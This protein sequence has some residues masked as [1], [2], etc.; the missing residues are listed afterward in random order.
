[1]LLGLVT[2]P[3]LPAPPA[4]A[5]VITAP[6]GIGTGAGAVGSLLVL[7]GAAAPGAWSDFLVSFVATSPIGD[8]G[9][10]GVTGQ[11]PF[12]GA[13]AGVST[14]DSAGDCPAGARASTFD[15]HG[16][17]VVQLGPHCRVPVGDRLYVEF[18]AQAPTTA[19]SL[20]V[21]TSANPTPAVSG[22]IPVT[23]GP[24]TVVAS[25]DQAGAPSAYLMSDIPVPAEAAG[26]ST[27]TLAATAQRGTGTVAWSAG[28]AGYM[29]TYVPPGG[30]GGLDPVVASSPTSRPGE[31]VLHLS[32]PLS[33]GGVVCLAAQ[34]S[35][36]PAGTGDTF[37]VKVGDAAPRAAA[38]GVD[39]LSAVGSPS[40]LVAPDVSGAVAL[41]TVQFA[42]SQAL[43]GGDIVLSQPE[44]DFSTVS[45][46]TLTDRTTGINY[47]V[48]GA[49]LTY[50]K[51]V[52]P[53]PTGLGPGDVVRVTLSGVGNP[54]A[55]TVTDFAVSTSADSLPVFAPAYD[56]GQAGDVVTVSAEP[57]TPGATADYELSGLV[58][59]AN[60]PADV[61]TIRLSAPVGT[62]LPSN[63]ADYYVRDATTAGS[64]GT[65][66]L[67]T[68]GGGSASVTFAVPQAVA[69]GDVMDLVVHDVVNP[70][71]SGV[72]TLALGGPV[73]GPA[74]GTSTSFPAA[75]ISYPDGSIIDFGGTL[76][77]MAGGH[78]FGVVTPAQATGVEAVDRAGVLQALPGAS[79]PSAPPAPG[80]L[81]TPFNSPTVYVVGADRLLHGF[82]TPAQLLSDGYDPAQVITVPNL[83]GLSVGAT[84][85]SLGMAADAL[86]TVSNGAIVTSGGAFYV[87]A[88]GRAFAVPNQ[89]V[90]A[91]VRAAD[92]ALPL[93]GYV[94]GLLTS[95]PV[96]DGTLA[97]VGGVVYVAYGGQFYPATSLAELRAAG[98]AGTPSIVLPSTGG[99]SIAAR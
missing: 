62:V 83:G 31:V 61:G 76:Y 65:A 36:P 14:W 10:V 93:A 54:P 63:P 86:S 15:S 23:A 72:Y 40:V 67:L 24:A 4:Y 6:Y 22:A 50:G 56:I 41:Y 19:F 44:T 39:Y 95:E 71:A 11:G 33:G 59:S 51:A 53:V 48:S 99:V 90:L 88:G 20:Q 18:G 91:Q 89:L 27:L 66:A 75:N 55:G 35:N 94:P 34:G 1:M 46:V 38:E 3:V 37:S 92:R 30:S 97:T 16:G 21:V 5:D 26:A 98:F 28:A 79:V 13:V 69:A 29:V 85:G 2:A 42:A 58:A 64:S 73:T 57:S 74:T 8:G 70:P 49:T 68:A 87:L 43:T 25:S 52:V 60:L 82:A 17:L 96:S 84:A 80:T 81:L 45:E 12:V 7:P 77:V 32:Q 78:G 9:T 47:P